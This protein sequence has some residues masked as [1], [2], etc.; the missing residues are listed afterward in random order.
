ML[1]FKLCPRCGGDLHHDRD[2]YGNYVA[3]LQCGYYLPDAEMILLLNPHTA[4]QETIGEPE[5]QPALVA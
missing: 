3:C 4:K 1:W 2:I 5:R